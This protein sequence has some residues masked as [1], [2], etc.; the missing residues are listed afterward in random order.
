VGLYSGFTWPRPANGEPGAWVEI[1]GELVTGMN[2][3]HAFRESELVNWID[4][5]L[6]EVELNGQIVEMEGLLVARRG[7]LL[8][9]VREW[10]SGGAGDFAHGCIRSARAHAIAALRRAGRHRQANRLQE[11]DEL[12]ELQ[13]SAAAGA[14]EAEGFSADALAFVADAV[15]LSQGGRPERYREHPGAS[16]APT[17]GAIASNLA[18]VVAHAAGC[19]AADEARDPDAYDKG[20]AAERDRQRAWLAARLRLES[21][22]GAEPNHN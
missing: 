8:R 18:F 13:A 2:G 4:D 15:E 10:D 22:G 21:Q 12:Q 7:R 9:Q 16:I 6:W 5:E 19:A 17:P 14:R 20:F 3:V 11:L 1:D